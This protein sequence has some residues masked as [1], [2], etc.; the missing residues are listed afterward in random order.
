MNIATFIKTVTN[1]NVKR[2][3]IKKVESGC[4]LAVNSNDS[5]FVKG[6]YVVGHGGYTVTQIS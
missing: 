3:L 5:K 6:R 4:N 1:E 2:L